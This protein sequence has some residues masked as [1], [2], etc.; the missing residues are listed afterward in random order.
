MQVPDRNQNRMKFIVGTLLV[1]GLIAAAGVARSGL[2]TYEAVFEPIIEINLRQDSNLALSQG[3]QVMV[4]FIKDGC[5]PCVQMKQEV[6]TDPA[7]QAYFKEHFLSYH[8][9]IFGDLP[10]IDASGVALT[11]KTYAKQEGIWGTPAFYFFGKHGQ[12]VHK[13]IGALTKNDFVRLGQ[14]VA[15]RRN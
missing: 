3:K 12:L 14:L 13:H 5:S 15:A 8:V 10:F 9:N 7:V 6:L 11:E 2:A 1:V 4:M